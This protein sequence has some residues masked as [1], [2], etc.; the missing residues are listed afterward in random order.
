MEVNMTICFKSNLCFTQCDRP[1]KIPGYAPEVL[2][3][4]VLCSFFYLCI[5]FKSGKCYNVIPC[6]GSRV[7]IAQGQHSQMLFKEDCQ[8]EGVA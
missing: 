8:C 6:K 2:Y 4:F 5:A 1:L 3:C 7:L